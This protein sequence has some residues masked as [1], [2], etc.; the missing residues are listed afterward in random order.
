MVSVLSS[1][2]LTQVFLRQ[3]AVVIDMS[4]FSSDLVVLSVSWPVERGCSMGFSGGLHLKWYCCWVDVLHVLQAHQVFIMISTPLFL[5]K[6]GNVF[7]ELLPKFLWQ[8]A[9]EGWWRS[10]VLISD[11]SLFAE[12]RSPS[13]VLFSSEAER[14]FSEASACKVMSCFGRIMSKFEKLFHF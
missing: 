12:L 4:R 5:S 7:G 14:E 3:I 8:L 6:H 1:A 9:H 13:F 11:G 2:D 10:L